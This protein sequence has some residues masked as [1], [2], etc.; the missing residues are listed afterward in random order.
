ML[1]DI[2]HNN[3]L[4]SSSAPLIPQLHLL[5]LILSCLDDYSSS[6]KYQILQE[7]PFNGQAPDAAAP[8]AGTDPT[9]QHP[10]HANNQPV[11][12]ELTLQKDAYLVFRALCKLSHRTS[13]NSA[14]PDTTV[15]KGKVRTSLA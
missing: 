8:K 10:S 12:I 3:N 15:L 4:C 9:A 6:Q 13:E 5:A 1:V 2:P 7:G 14:G 11:P